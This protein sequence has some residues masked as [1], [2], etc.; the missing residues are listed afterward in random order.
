[1]TAREFP[2]QPIGVGIEVESVDDV[3]AAVEK[4]GGN[5]IM[6]KQQIPQRAWFALCQDSEGNSFIAYQKL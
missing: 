6:G 5:V 3:I 2:G 1:M 4:N